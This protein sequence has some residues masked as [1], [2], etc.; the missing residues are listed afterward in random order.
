VVN[1]VVLAVLA[2]WGL[3]Q[4]LPLEVAAEWEHFIKL[5]VSEI[6]LEVLEEILLLV[7]GRM[8]HKTDNRVTQGLTAAAVVV[9]GKGM[10]LAQ[11]L[12]QVVARVGMW[13]LL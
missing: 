11:V 4:A 2:Q 3:A 7:A 12:V 9:R 10:S 6:F 13:T 5:Q 1:P 8:P